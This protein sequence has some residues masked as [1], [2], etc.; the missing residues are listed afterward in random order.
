MP[1]RLLTTMSLLSS[2]ARA[3]CASPGGC[4]PTIDSYGD[5]R[6]E[7]ITADKLECRELAQQSSGDAVTETG[8][9]AVIGGLLDAATGAAIGAATGNPGKGAA[10]GAAT[11]G[12]GGGAYQALGNNDQ[13]K[14]AYADCMRH[15][16][17][18]VVD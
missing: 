3:G 1:N 2:F 15:R 18:H 5:S 11:G 7:R 14:I 10:I 8:K 17:H 12:I 16:G 13:F 9:G 6:P 4:S